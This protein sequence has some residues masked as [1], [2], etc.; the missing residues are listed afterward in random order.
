MENAVDALKQAVAVFIFVIALT[1]SFIMFSKAKQTAD[2]VTTIQDKQEYLESAEL[3]GTLYTSSNTI[4]NPSEDN[5]VSGITQ[6][7][8]R[9]VSKDDVI[10]TI[11]R[12]YLEKYGVTIID[13]DGNVIA[14]F[15]SNTEAIVQQWN[16]LDEDTRRKVAERIRDNLNSRDLKEY[17]SSSTDKITFDEGTI[18]TLYKIDKD[19]A[20]TGSKLVGAPWVGNS[21]QII[22]RINADISGGTYTYTGATYNKDKEE[23]KKLSTVLDNNDGK[24]IEILT[25]IDNSEYLKDS[26]AETSLL[27]QYELP[28]VEI[29]YIVY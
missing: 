26:G 14:R 4:A 16:L 21:K 1:S 13:S 20:S 17:I 7:G 12:Y 29:I 3:D 2:A 9:I 5:N 19:G 11:Y 24:F 10:S 27:Q 8:D 6:Y 23:N 22:K 15:D 25:E 28:T 18:E